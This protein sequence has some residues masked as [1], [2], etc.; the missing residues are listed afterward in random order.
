MLTNV[1][2]NVRLMSKVNMIVLVV[3]DEGGD[4][5]TGTCGIVIPGGITPGTVGCTG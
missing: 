2:W 3:G 1:D 5:C 4:G